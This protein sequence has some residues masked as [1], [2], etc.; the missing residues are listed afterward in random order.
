L[1]VLDLFDNPASH[2]PNYKMR[3]LNDLKSLQIHDK[4]KLSVIEKD[5]AVKFMNE[6]RGKKKK[7]RPFAW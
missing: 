4:H 3:V 6:F 5:E 1:K 2:E 7:T